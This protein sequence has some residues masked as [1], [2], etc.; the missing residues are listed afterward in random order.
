MAGRVD[1]TRPAN[2]GRLGY[3][4]GLDG[5]RALA[6]LTVVAF[7]V[8]AFAHRSTLDGGFLGVQVFFVISGFLI[9]ALLVEEHDRNRRIS[10]RAFY[11]RRALRLFPALFATVAA[12][13]VYTTFAPGSQLHATGKESIASLFYWDNWYH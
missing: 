4:P 2:A 9:T 13:V 12:S 6:I 8:G 3:L 11:A 7:H 5:L 10:L 1:T